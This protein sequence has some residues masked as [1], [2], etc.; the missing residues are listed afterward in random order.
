M[1]LPHYGNE[2]GAWRKQLTATYSEV[3]QNRANWKFWNTSPCMFPVM[4]LLY[5]YLQHRGTEFP[6]R[7]SY[8]MP[9]RPKAS[10]TAVICDWS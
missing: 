1:Q 2:F 8:G 5:H 6:Q 4:A 9:Q 7:L 3:A 10:T